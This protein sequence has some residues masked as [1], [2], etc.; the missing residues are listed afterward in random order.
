LGDPSLEIN[1]GSGDRCT[2]I[3]MPDD[4]RHLRIDQLL[5]DCGALFWICPVVLRQKFKFDLLPANLDLLLIQIFDGEPRTVFI[6]FSKMGLITGQWRDVTNFDHRLGVNKPGGGCKDSTH[7]N[8]LC[9]V[10]RLQGPRHK[11]LLRGEYS[12]AS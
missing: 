5:C 6:I 2:G 11:M 3:Q 7:R 8:R 10:R 9:D 4:A 1:L 12:P